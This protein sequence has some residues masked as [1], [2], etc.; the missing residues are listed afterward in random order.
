MKTPRIKKMVVLACAVCC[1]GTCLSKIALADRIVVPEP[2]YWLQAMLEPVQDK[3]STARGAAYFVVFQ[4]K[5]NCQFE[6]FVRGV[7]PGCRLVFILR[8]GAAGQPIGWTDAN[9]YGLA[10]LR[11]NTLHGD[12]VPTCQAGDFVEVWTVEPTNPDPKDPKRVSKRAVNP[13]VA[14]DM[15]YNLILKGVLQ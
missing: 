15:L 14:P 2:L 4:D 12:Y 11:V 6:A 13:K 3:T 10:G 1:L 7:E 5:A 9:R 8:R